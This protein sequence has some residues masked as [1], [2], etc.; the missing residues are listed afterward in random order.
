MSFS[1]YDTLGYI[2]DILITI[3]ILN[4]FFLKILILL[5]IIY[6]LDIISLKNINL[7]HLIKKESFALFSLG[8]Q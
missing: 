1:L 7:L 3:G 8:L 4:P 6:K 2:I 5:Y